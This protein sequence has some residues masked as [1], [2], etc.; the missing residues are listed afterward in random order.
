[1]VRMYI[2]LKKGD[3]PYEKCA[4]EAVHSWLYGFNIVFYH[5][6]LESNICPYPRGV[7]F[8]K[9]GFRNIKG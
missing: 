7:S 3:I 6:H 2:Q 9:R 5:Y 4:Y 8:Q 1:M